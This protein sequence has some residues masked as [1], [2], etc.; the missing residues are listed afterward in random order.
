MRTKKRLGAFIAVMAMFL[1]ACGG[2][3]GTE[4]SNNDS[5][6]TQPA[7]AG[8]ESTTTGP[9][10]ELDEDAIF[11][12]SGAVGPTSFDP[13]KSASSFDNA[14]L[15]LTYDRLVH[16]TASS[17]PIPGLAT[18]WELSDDNSSILFTL[19]EDVTFHDGTPF[20]AEAVKAN[21]E[22]VK[23]VEG[24]TLSSQLDMVDTV[25]I[26]SDNSV[27][28]KLNG[29]PG[30]LIL[31]LSDAAGM[32]VSPAAFENPKLALQPVGA[33]MYE[34]ANYEPNGKIEYRPYAD[35]W[36]PEAI[37]VAGIDF[38]VQDS[39]ARLNALREG[40]VHLGLIESSQEQSAEEAG[41]KIQKSPT[42]AFN[43]MQLN[44]A[45]SEF[46]N[47]L[48]RQAMNYAIDREAIVDA[49]VN[50]NGIP[51]AQPFPPGYFAHS[52]DAE[53]IY[54]YNP[55]KAREL[56]AEA[57]LADGFSFDF[58]VVALPEFE[59]LGQ[60]LQAQL[61]E[62]GIDAQI[63]ALSPA[64]AA[65]SFYFRQE[66]DAA[67]LPWGGRPDPSMTLELLY[68]E[69]ADGSAEGRNPGGVPIEGLEGVL[70][71]ANALTDADARAEKLQEATALVVEQA[72]ELIVYFPTAPSAQNERVVGAD[73]YL[74]GKPEYRGIGL[75]AE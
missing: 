57:G 54:S 61:A 32:M 16:L 2:D 50:G 37:N 55:E 40:T 12:M 13:H 47:P 68:L 63:T 46:G 44:R 52:A 31:T 70:N 14:T 62:V 30:A 27:L 25:E 9:E 38:L 51:S 60:V 22:R 29:S 17:E 24:G 19:R 73:R 41:L 4:N 5:S 69:N 21:I 42:L 28:F 36:E 23:T 34:V 53:S 56:L 67:L 49:V 66:G 35:Y 8:G 18:S 48:V 3:S 20:N 39:E 43:H 10:V 33:G 64:D 45:R 6:T 1:G 7:L 11:V 59:A 74:S 75:A 65:Q 26:V 58:R 72:A 15:A 71:E